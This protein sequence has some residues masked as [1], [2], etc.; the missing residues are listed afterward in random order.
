MYWGADMASNSK[1]CC[2]E[3]RVWVIER[4]KARKTVMVGVPRMFVT[5]SVVCQIGIPSSKVLSSE[6]VQKG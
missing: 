3:A 4:K 1:G 2:S 5:C 6:D